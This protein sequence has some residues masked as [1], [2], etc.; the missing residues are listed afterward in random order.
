MIEKKIL[1][2][3]GNRINKVDFSMEPLEPHAFRNLHSSPLYSVIWLFKGNIRLEI[4]EHQHQIAAPA[5]VFL[6]QYQPYRIQRHSPS[7][8]GILAQFSSDFYCIHLHQKEVSCDGVLFNSVFDP[9][10]FSLATEE[11]VKLRQALEDL[12]D[13]FQR[14]KQ[15]AEMLFTLLKLLL[16]Q[17]VRLRSES[18]ESLEKIA[19]KSEVFIHFK[20]LLEDSFRNR[21]TPSDYAEKLNMRVETLNRIIKKQTGLTL[22]GIIQ[23]RIVAEAK[24]ELY[25]SNKPIKQIAEELGFDDPFYFSRIFKNASNVSPEMYRENARMTNHE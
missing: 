21:L 24:R 14:E 15:D 11:S 6:S 13:E 17:A 16:K 1:N 22:S 8:G 9:P 4:E 10:H 23:G 5:V 7:T 25:L 12:I 2:L 20:Q 3:G 18:S 19:P